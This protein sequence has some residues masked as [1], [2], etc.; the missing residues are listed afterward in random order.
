MRKERLN[1]IKIEDLKKEIRELS[2]DDYYTLR[3]WIKEENQRRSQIKS[4]ERAAAHRKKILSFRLGHKLVVKRHFDDDV[5]LG[6]MVKITRKK[7][8]V[9]RISVQ[10]IRTGEIW[11]VPISDLDEP[12]E[13]VMKNIEATEGLRSLFR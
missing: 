2:D 5:R 12:T 1:E 8:S 10:V 13:E 11:R 6:D 9:K 7:R 3:D 4:K